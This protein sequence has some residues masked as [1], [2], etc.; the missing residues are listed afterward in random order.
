M[1]TLTGKAEKLRHIQRAKGSLNLDG[2]GTITELKQLDVFPSA[3]G[4]FVH[5]TL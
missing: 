5:D 4:S 3:V 2:I 1:D